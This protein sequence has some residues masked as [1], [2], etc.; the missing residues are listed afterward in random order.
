MLPFLKNREG[1]SSVTPTD[2]ITRDH[3]ETFDMLGAVADDMLSAI[4]AGDKSALK[5]ALSAF[6]DHVRSEDIPE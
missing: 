4:K 5:E 2:T 1:A 6:A 3:D